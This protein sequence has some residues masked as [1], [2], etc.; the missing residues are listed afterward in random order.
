MCERL[1]KDAEIGD[2]VRLHNGKVVEIKYLAYM[3]DDLHSSY[4]YVIE[5]DGYSPSTYTDDGL[6][7]EAD[8]ACEIDIVEVIKRVA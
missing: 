7:A 2:S 3:P 4:S 8:T 1:L 6:W 5:L